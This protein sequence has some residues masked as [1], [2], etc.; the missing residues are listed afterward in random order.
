M[1]KTKE[2]EREIGQREK[3]FKNSYTGTAK[4]MRVSLLG[5]GGGGVVVG[6]GSSL[7]GFTAT[8]MAQE[9]QSQIN[10]AC[11]LPLQK[12]PLLSKDDNS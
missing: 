6:G 2:R 5:L 12:R 11:S 1:Q 8:G 10:K 7:V 3:T 4:I 9:V